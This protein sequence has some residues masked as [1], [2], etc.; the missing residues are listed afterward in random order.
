MKPTS[1]INVIAGAVAA[2]AVAGGLAL[3]YFQP[4]LVKEP[5]D[6][7]A[8]ASV[9]L[10]KF[11]SGTFIKDPI[12][13][14]GEQTTVLTARHCTKGMITPSEGI[15]QVI[16][17]SN[18]SGISQDFK[19]VLV[20]EESDLA[21]LQPVIDDWTDARIVTADVVREEIEYKFGTPVSSVGYPG[22]TGKTFTTGHLG[23]VEEVPVFGLVSK[24]KRFQKSTTMSIGGSSGQG[25]FVYDDGYKLMGVLTGGM[26]AFV[27]F[28]TPMD[29]VQSFLNTADEVYSVNNAN[30]EVSEAVEDIVE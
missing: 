11:C 24:T 7:R 5:V 4:N 21:L 14:D 30:K 25:L 20:S 27:N 28:Y 15:G 3:A 23:Y 17:I 18:E 26:G 6:T 9:Q 19:V 12:T 29:E 13:S 10:G 2:A 22:G 8:E 1:V 16:K